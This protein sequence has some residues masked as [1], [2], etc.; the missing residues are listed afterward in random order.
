MLKNYL[1]T[2]WR[3]ILKNKIYAAINIL[4][5]VVGLSVYLFSSLLANYEQSHDL[6]FE[7]ADRTFTVGS[8]FSATA[9]IGVSQTDGVYSAVGPF[10]DSEVPEVEAVARTVKQEFLV[11]IDKNDYYQ[12]I[13]F[14]DP[15]LLEIFNLDYIEGDSRAL[16]DPKGVLL[17]SSAASKFFGEGPALGK[18]MA[19]DHDINLHVTAVV[20][21]LPPN[22]H[23]NSGIDPDSKFDVV[24]PLTALNA[25]ADYDLEGNWGNLSMGDMTYMLLP[26]DT[27]LSS[28]QSSLD[29]LY[30]RHL[31]EDTKD[32]IT[33][34][35]VRPLV[36]A[37]T[38]LWDAIGLP[39]LE[40]IQF[41]GL[42]VL[43]VAIV[44]YTNLATAQSLARAREVGLRKTLGAEQRQLLVQFLVESLSI[45]TIS[46]FVALA[47]LE[48]L[49]PLFNTSLDRALTLDYVVTLPWLVATTIIVGLVSGAYPAYMITQASPIEALRDGGKTGAK[50]NLFRSVMLGLQFA[51]SIFM[52][53]IVF[54]AYF[55]NS[56]I[57][58][59]SEIYPKSQILS[60]ERLNVDSIQ[61][62]LETLRYE[63]NALPGV[64]DVAYSSQV[65]FEQ[66]NASFLTGSVKGDETQSF[67]MNQIIV[68]FDFMRTYDIPLLAGRHFS[69]DVSADTLKETET[70][71]SGN[72]L[73][74]DQTE[75]NVIVNELALTRLG[76]SSPADALNK[77]FYDF[78]DDT[79]DREARVYTIVG[80]MPDQ[81]FLG[82]FNKIKP[83]MFMVRPAYLRIGSVR[84]KG[85]GL[86]A[87]VREIENVW[88]EVI[89]DYPIQAKFLDETFNDVFQIIS[90]MTKVLSGFAFLALT[91]SM[92]GLFGL[93]AFMAARRT[94]E[95]GIRK[96]MGADLGQ[97]VRMLIWQFSKPVMWALVV[98]L[99]ASY[100]ASNI[101]LGFFADRLD[102]TEVIVLSSG[103][104]AIF[105]SWAIVAI[106]AVKIARSNPIHALRYE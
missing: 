61:E 79:Q 91:L 40:A 101:Y 25:V 37:N 9:N 36:E 1:T 64:V 28:V 38:I 41:L 89:F 8:T 78:P 44:N 80:V 73:G 3:N 98:A 104:L 65:P 103:A 90:A 97:I 21:D 106:H 16:D 76:F 29:G 50:G 52:L 7:N 24:A 58:T 12:T 72:K 13:R 26:A 33:G 75:V 82:L 45:A 4:G 55:Q 34:F 27:S 71:E 43:I 95:I 39:V 11:S 59:S 30:E 68:D 77:V 53:S 67:L 92:I 100:V 51:I 5:L 31:P 46:M 86:Q 35:R 19:L 74:E 23:L 62:R 10:I 56:R 94:K 85:T 96:V 83:I 17:T 93:A 18:T 15:A 81:N 48:V 84:V 70:D 87:T 66:H 88:D 49:I 99:P 14:A 47:M 20:R 102:L 42:L 6:F 105:L 60:L 2:A 63:L 32:F 57:E 22:T 69:Q 54:V